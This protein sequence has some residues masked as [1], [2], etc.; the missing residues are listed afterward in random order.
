M[1][2]AWEQV[3]CEFDFDGSWRDVYVL[4]VERHHWALILDALRSSSFGLSFQ[5]GGV[6]ATF[7]ISLDGFFSGDSS[8]L[9]LVD[10]G[11]PLMACHFFSP[12]EIEFDLDPREFSEQRHLDGLI[13]FMRLLAS[14]CQRPAILTPE[15]L[16]E[17]PIIT[18][19]SDGEVTYTPA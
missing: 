11:G 9:L 14:A 10:I 3:A 2:L 4:G 1:T 5:G 19:T 16:Q 7:P 8:V 12:D 15:N 13:R 18:V 6:E 17:A